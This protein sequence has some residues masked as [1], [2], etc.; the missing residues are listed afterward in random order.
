MLKIGTLADWFG[1][2]LINGIRE[3]QRCGAQ[4]VQL[5]AA[6]EL[7]PYNVTTEQIRTIR[8]VAQDCG[9]Q[10]TAICGEL[11]GHGLQIAENNPKNL[12]TLKRTV[13]L[14]LELDCHIVTTHIGVLPDD[15][16]HSRYQIML[17]AGQEIGAYAANCG[18][19][20]AIETGPEMIKTLKMYVDDCR[21]GVAINYDPA[22]IVMVTR[23]DEVQGVYT[24]GNAIVHTHAKD[25]RCDRYIGGEAFYNKLF[26][27]DGLDGIGGYCT[28]L[29]LGQGD[30]RWNAYIKALLD[31]G[32]DGFL[33]IEREV[34]NGAEDIRMAVDF[35]K[36]LLASI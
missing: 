33:T 13:D 23:D 8:S 31:I 12:E 7:D 36:Q 22:N 21:Q 24:A 6:N 25:G 2:G 10:I 35:L 16:K 20:I 3:S 15:P 26:A 17:E 18:S 34:K 19:C 1:V 4:G 29:P 9:Q 5:Y 27:D 28:E 14:A 11:G 30:V 32:Y